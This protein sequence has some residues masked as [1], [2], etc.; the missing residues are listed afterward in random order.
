L[1]LLI[2]KNPYGFFFISLAYICLFDKIV[3]E[4]K[5]QN[6]KGVIMSKDKQTEVLQQLANQ[7]N[8]ARESLKGAE[9]M[10]K[11]MGLDPKDLPVPTDEPK[12][13]VSVPREQDSS[14]SG[15]DPV[16][17]II[18]GHFDGQNMIGPD[19]KTYPVPANYAS[20]SK[21]IEGDTLKLT[22]SADGS[23]IYKQIGPIDRKKLIAKID[24]DNGQY[25]AVVG[26]A[27]Y[28]VLYA[29]VTYFKAQPGDEVTVVVPAAGDSTWA[30]IEAVIGS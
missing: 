15:Q 26:N 13:L 17:K 7:M 16:G 20:K 1:T 4:R 27:H 9:E 12:P 6:Q 22:I 10:L 30:A 21:L 5:E 28:K 18:E 14:S 11:K 29:S 24:L 3:Y 25:I 23:F 2:K 8:D 19:G